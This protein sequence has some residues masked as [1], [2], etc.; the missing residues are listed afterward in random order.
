MKLDFEEMI[1]DALNLNASRAAIID[2]ADIK[3]SNELR[4]MCKQNMCGSYKSNWMCPPAIGPLSELKEKVLKYKQG[5]V[6]QTIHPLEDSF[7]I[8]GMEEAQ[9]LHR[10]IFKNILDSIKEKYKFDNVL[11]LS[12]GA[13]DICSECGYVHGKD[14]YFPE[15]AISSVE[16]YGINA[17]ALVTSC[18]FPYN[19]GQNTVSYVGLILFDI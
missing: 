11:P 13:C 7:D 3:F 12:A 4:Q 18:G 6:I 2:V 15:K 5:F 19:N 8:E 16:A 14:C 17:M 9:K 1:Q 10:K